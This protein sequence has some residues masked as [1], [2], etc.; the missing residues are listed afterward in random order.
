MRGRAGGSACG[1]SFQDAAILREHDRDTRT[2]QRND[3]VPYP[4]HLERL[5][6]QM[7]SRFDRNNVRLVIAMPDGHGLAWVGPSIPDAAERRKGCKSGVDMG[8]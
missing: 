1:R 5:R 7:A 6:D 2:W 3:A 8:A 4:P